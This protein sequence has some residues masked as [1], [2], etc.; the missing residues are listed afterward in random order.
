MSSSLKLIDEPHDLYG[1]QR[2][3]GNQCH[4]PK[5][6]RYHISADSG[7]CSH[8]KRKQKRGRH[9]TCSNADGVKRHCEEL[10]R[11]GI[12]TS[13]PGVQST[14]LTFFHESF[15]SVFSCQNIFNPASIILLVYAFRGFMITSSVF[16]SS[17]TLPL[18]MTITR[19]QKSCTRA[20]S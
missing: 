11:R 15:I 4:D 3:Q 17:A 9:G 20:R 18:Y 19:S 10:C 14:G 8:C 7:T 2:S 6:V 12:I 5:S 16:P 13:D 1:D